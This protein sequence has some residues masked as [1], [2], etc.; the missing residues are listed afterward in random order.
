M[1]PYQKQETRFLGIS[2]FARASVSRYDKCL[3]IGIPCFRRCPPSSYQMNH[4]CMFAQ[5]WFFLR[6]NLKRVSLAE[7]RGDLD[8]AHGGVHRISQGPTCCAPVVAP[9]IAGLGFRWRSENVPTLPM[10]RSLHRRR[11]FLLEPSWSALVDQYLVVET[12]SPLVLLQGDTISE[13]FY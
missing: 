9:P 6:L 8:L 3:K 12:L 1:L 7:Q 5:L 10:M 11:G 2:A 13:Q 4:W